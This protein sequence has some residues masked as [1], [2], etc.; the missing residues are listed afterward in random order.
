MLI[1]RDPSSR[2][3]I[4]VPPNGV[5]RFSSLDPILALTEPELILGQGKLQVDAG[6]AG[7]WMKTRTKVLMDTQTEQQSR[8]LLNQV[9]GRLEAPTMHAL[10]LADG[11]DGAKTVIN[12]TNETESSQAVGFTLR[13][14]NAISSTM[15]TLTLGAS[16]TVDVAEL[17]DGS[18]DTGALE[19]TSDAPV[20]VAA[21]HVLEN[22]YG[23]EIISMAPVVR[24]LSPN[25][26][27]VLP[28]VMIGRIRNRHSLVECRE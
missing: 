14:G 23:E 26:V 16:M 9:A 21:W 22:K 10:V 7:L 18:F 8:L 6:V 1:F 17:L 25:S 13:S 15:E 24:G 20:S 5:A 2:H 11:R 28:H 19:V 27:T 12:V 4:E 3:R